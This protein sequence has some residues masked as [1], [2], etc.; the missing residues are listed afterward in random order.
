MLCLGCC[1]L[2]FH[3]FNIDGFSLS[4]TYWRSRLQTYSILVL[5]FVF[6]L[7]LSNKLISCS[8]LLICRSQTSSWSIHSSLRPFFNKQRLN[9]SITLYCTN[10]MDRKMDDL[11]TL[12]VEPPSTIWRF[13]MRV[14]HGVPSWALPFFTDRFNDRFR[15]AEL[16][17]DTEQFA[18]YGMSLG[19]LSF[20]TWWAQKTR[21]VFNWSNFFAY[22][23]KSDVRVNGVHL[24]QMCSICKRECRRGAETSQ[25]RNR[26]NSK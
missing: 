14:H 23:K 5:S 1:D 7:C 18:H 19:H 2:V 10:K 9:I 6:R 4:R 13:K 17:N 25:W 12:V 22:C 21:A 8:K 20:M 11:L 16:R 3:F 24:D 26:S 15:Y